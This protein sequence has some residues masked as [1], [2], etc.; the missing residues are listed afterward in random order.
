MRT[1]NRYNSSMCRVR[2]APSPTGYLHVGGAR[3]GEMDRSTQGSPAKY[4]YCA[5]ENTE[6]SPWEPFAVRRGFGGGVLARV[7]GH[8]GQP[9]L[10]DRVPGMGRGGRRGLGV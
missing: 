7:I 8:L 6:D 5:A 4:T 10:R 2:F 9:G 1:L 3:P